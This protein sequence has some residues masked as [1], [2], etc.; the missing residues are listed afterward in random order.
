MLSLDRPAIDWV[1]LARGYGVEA[2]RVED[3]VSFL[4]ALRAGISRKGPY[5]IEVTLD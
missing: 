1:S 4:Q 5:L 2:R 3:L